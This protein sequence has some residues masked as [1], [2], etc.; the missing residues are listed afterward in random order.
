MNH[1]HSENPYPEPTLY[2]R[3]HPKVETVLR[4]YQCETPIC[5]K[6]ARR[7]PV[8][9]MCPDC[10][11]GH[12]R[13]F[14][15]TGPTDYAVAA[16]AAVVLGGIASLLPAL[17]IWWF[18]LFLSPLAG[19][20]IAEAV[21][22]LVGRRY[23]RHLWWIVSAGIVVGALPSLGLSL[24]QLMT[25]LRGSLWGLSGILTWG[26][27]VALAVASAIARLRMG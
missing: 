12:K 16:I 9:Y 19:T 6:C 24:L 14:E 18:L 7:T 2:C 10:Q 1:S 20:L 11:R 5:V 26:L 15:Q 25:F 17:G 3:W 27:H 21:W 4:C 22:R 23:G 8:G 13:R